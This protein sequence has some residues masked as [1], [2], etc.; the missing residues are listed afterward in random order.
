MSDVK[1]TPGPWAI[2]QDETDDANEIEISSLS[3]FNSS[4]IPIC[5]ISIGYDGPVE[6]EQQ[7]NARLISAAP[8]LLEAAKV[9]LAY[10][11]VC[12][13]APSWTGESPYPLLRAA[14][15]K[16]LGEPQ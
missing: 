3:R 2:F 16:A 11:D 13:G 6:I 10:L 7:A 15:S 4:V 1:H 5:A 14:I 8:E 12:L 9:A